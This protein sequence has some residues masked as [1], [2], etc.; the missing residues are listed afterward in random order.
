MGGK[1]SKFARGA[2]RKATASTSGRG[3]KVDAVDELRARVHA[4]MNN[5]ELFE[6]NLKSSIDSGA[7][8]TLNELNLGALNIKRDN[9]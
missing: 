2:R 6:I 1:S 5:L 7:I 4:I 9:L 8:D 3:A